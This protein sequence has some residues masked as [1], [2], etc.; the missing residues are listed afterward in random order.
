MHQQTQ[1]PDCF[2]ALV[3]FWV[4]AGRDGG[5]AVLSRSK[6]S[7]IQTK[8]RELRNSARLMRE[9]AEDTKLPTYAERMIRIAEELER[10][11]AELVK[12]YAGETR[13]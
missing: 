11:A 13:N 10:R 3:E 6:T 12:Q 1:Y 4:I 9:Q 7:M 5:A 8:A 2:V